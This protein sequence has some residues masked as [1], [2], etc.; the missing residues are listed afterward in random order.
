MQNSHSETRLQGKIFKR[1]NFKINTME[2]HYDKARKK[3]YIV[4][5]LI[6]DRTKRGK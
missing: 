6:E 5:L 3:I 2:S 1:R 4:N